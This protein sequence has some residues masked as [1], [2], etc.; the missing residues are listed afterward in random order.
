MQ[1]G[2]SPE[3]HGCDVRIMMYE[4]RI[5]MYDFNKVHLSY[6]LNNYCRINFRAV[7]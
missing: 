2:K 4:L 5:T 1:P 6:L 7:I 3:L